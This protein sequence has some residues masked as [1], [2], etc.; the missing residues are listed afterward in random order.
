MHARLLLFLALTL[1]A[2]LTSACT[3]GR[4]TL[5]P[6][7]GLRA[8]PMF[9]PTELRDPEPDPSTERNRFHVMVRGE[10]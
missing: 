5:L 2:V 9:D 8:P 1:V 7:V 6:R 10:W 4:A 3:I